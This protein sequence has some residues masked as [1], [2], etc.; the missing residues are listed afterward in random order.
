MCKHIGSTKE[1]PQEVWD[2]FIKRYQ[3]SSFRVVPGHWPS[4]QTKEEVDDWI[5]YIEK[6]LNKA[7][8]K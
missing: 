4:F 8:R 2:Y 6:F 3:E 7:W 1:I 5:E